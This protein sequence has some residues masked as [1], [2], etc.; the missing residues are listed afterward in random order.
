MINRLS[1]QTKFFEMKHKQTNHECTD[2]NQ[3]LEHEKMKIVS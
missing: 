3:R 2:R 1:E